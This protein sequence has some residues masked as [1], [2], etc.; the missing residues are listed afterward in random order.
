M[1]EID[2]QT[3]AKAEAIREMFHTPKVPTAWLWDHEV[4]AWEKAGRDMQPLG[5]REDGKG[6]FATLRWAHKCKGLV[7][8]DE[9][10]LVFVPYEATRGGWY[11]VTLFDP[12]GVY[13]PSGYNILVSDSTCQ[14]AEQVYDPAEKRHGLDCNQLERLV[15]EYAAPDA[16]L[17][18][19]G[20]QLRN[21]A[22]EM[23]AYVCEHYYVSD[24][25]SPAITVEQEENRG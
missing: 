12:K 15:R 10:G 7:L 1:N 18:W 2:K 8:K 9:K 16:E 19:V 11:A 5:I 20:L 3:A 13:P 25:A 24:A 14:L 22:E 23:V 4:R 6:K 21:H 17:G